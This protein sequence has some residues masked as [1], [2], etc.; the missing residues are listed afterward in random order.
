MGRLGR[1]AIHCRI[2]TDGV[3]SQKE[4]ETLHVRRGR[5]IAA[6]HIP[7]PDPARAGRDA[8]LIGPTIVTDHGTHRVSTV[9][10]VVA[11]LG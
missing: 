7:A 5:S 4:L 3:G 10:I 1:I 8:D 11:R 9:A 6:I 2:A